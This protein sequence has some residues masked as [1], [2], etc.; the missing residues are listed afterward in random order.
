[1]SAETPDTAAL[2]RELERLRKENTLLR[3]EKD[4]LLRIATEYARERVLP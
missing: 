4:M 3:V 1:M 2:H